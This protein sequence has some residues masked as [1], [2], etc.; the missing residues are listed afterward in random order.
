MFQLKFDAS[1]FERKALQLNQ[2]LSEVPFALALTLN[3]A[4]T[5]ART[6]LIND[7]W[8]AHVNARNPSFMRT[9][10]QLKFA[11][12]NDLRA[13]IYDALGRGNLAIHDKGG[14][15]R[16]KNSRVLAVPLPNAVRRTQRGVAS[17]DKPRNLKRSFVTPKG[18]F[19]RRHGEVRQIYAFKESVTLRPDVPFTQTFA[20]VVRNEMRTHFPEA[21]A[22]AMRG[23]R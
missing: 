17:A 12:K 10:L 2:A 1:D 4:V 3:R 22:R 19:V 13:E 6:L 5:N 14:V 21:M 8:P 18:I 23:R 16:P 9:A 15:V 20:E 11:T 7:V